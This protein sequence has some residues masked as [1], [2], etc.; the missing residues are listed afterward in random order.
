MEAETGI[1]R[2]PPDLR[3]N[4]LG[5][6]NYKRVAV[7]SLH[8]IPGE[9]Y[10]SLMNTDVKKDFVIERY[11]NVEVL[12]SPC[13]VYDENDVKDVATVLY[14]HYKAKLAEKNHILLLMGHGNPDVNYNA[15]SNYSEA[16]E[17]LQQLAPNKNVFVGTVDY[18]DMLFWP[19]V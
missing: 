4:A 12:K 18:G 6:N 17:A 13:L 16:E 9:E 15:N 8:I 14:D 7:Q 5:K 10:L 2:Y 19:V 3:L 1:A 11:P